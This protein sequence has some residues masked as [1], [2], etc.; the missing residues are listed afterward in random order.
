MK[1]NTLKITVLVMCTIVIS[2]A[3]FS[4]LGAEIAGLSS[5]LDARIAEIAELAG[6][7]EEWHA[8]RMKEAILYEKLPDGRVGGKVDE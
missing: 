8:S 6:H 3:V 2:I 4:K 1:K 7:G 5:E